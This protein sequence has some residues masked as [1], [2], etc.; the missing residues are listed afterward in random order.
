L[1]SAVEEVLALVAEMLRRPDP[2]EPEFERTRNWWLSQ[3]RA[4]SASDR[5]DE[6]VAAA[7]YPVGHPYRIAP[8]GNIESLTALRR[9]D[10]LTFLREHVAPDQV[11][12]VGAG[13]VTWLTF[14]ESV[15]KGFGDWHG[16]AIPEPTLPAIAPS[17]GDAR[18]LVVDR[19]GAAQAEIRIAAL[20]PPRD[21]PDLVPFHLLTDALGG[22]F[23]SR[24][25]LN[26]REQHGYSYT[27]HTTIDYE[28]G[29]GMFTAIARV[30]TNRVGESVG[31]MAREL[32][33]V[34]KE[35]L[36][37]AELDLAKAVLIVNLRGVF[38]TR[39]ATASTLSLLISN[40]RPIDD[41]AEFSRRAASMKAAELRAVA[42]RY[43]DPTQR[44]TV[45]M[46]DAKAIRSQ[47]PGQRVETWVSTG[48]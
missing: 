29:P 14:S 12:V 44:R 5:M 33:R 41:Y 6:A 37:P 38:S 10:A 46:G 13:D 34:R 7:L 22:N 25:L 15:K 8:D 24:I 2:S 35:D 42:Q 3:L 23:T 27:P 45:I 36:A 48:Q 9:A 17:S 32:D 20:C 47:L 39:S 43:L 1:P 19:P 30:P 31:E 40:R 21:S 11:V 16:V 18:I 26:L 4:R 28:R